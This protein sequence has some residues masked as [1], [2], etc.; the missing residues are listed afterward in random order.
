MFKPNTVGETHLRVD[1]YGVSEPV[2]L[3]TGTIIPVSAVDAVGATG[4]GSVVANG[5][6]PQFQFRKVKQGNGVSVTQDATDVTV[7]NNGN[8]AD[9][10]AAV[11]TIS[12]VSDSGA[13][14][15]DY[16]TKKIVIGANMTITQNATDV[17]IASVGGSSTTLSSAGGSSLVTD[18]TGPSLAIVGVA[19]S[20]SLKSNVTATTASFDNPCIRVSDNLG[21]QPP[22]LEVA[23]ATGNSTTAIG[24]SASAVGAGATAYGNASDAGALSASAFGEGANA[25]ANYAVACGSFSVASGTEGCGVGHQAQATGLNST[26]VSG[27]ASIAGGNNSLTAGYQNVVNVGANSAAAVGY[28]N[29]VQAAGI[30]SQ[31]FGATNTSSASNAHIFG[32]GLTNA[33]ASTILFGSG[34]TKYLR[35]TASGT[36]TQTTNNS[37]AVTVNATMGVITMFGAVSAGATETFL[38]NNS[39]VTASSV[40]ILTLGKYAGGCITNVPNIGAGS[41]NINVNNVSLSAT[42]QGPL[43]NFLVLNPA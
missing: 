30:G 29:I 21:N 37:T 24:G 35:L 4:T 23:T 9:A 11:G 19:D 3:A 28:A 8:L 32:T 43:I 16:R 10:A 7:T 22:T 1:K 25:S 27:G 12:L 2:T 6:A 42:S 18:G 15:G 5:T 38:V 20:A 39:Y 26:A 13:T 14:T 31:V 17:T 36:V 40:V 41:F 34:G 33:A